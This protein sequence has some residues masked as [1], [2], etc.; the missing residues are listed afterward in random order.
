MKKKPKTY[1]ITKMGKEIVI[2]ILNNEYKVIVCWGDSEFVNKVG[3]KWQYPSGDIKI[4]KGV[5]GYTAINKELNPIIVLRNRPKR[6][7]EFGT[8]AHEAVHA[9]CNIW[10][11]IEEKN[12][13]EVFAHSV[14]AIVRETLNTD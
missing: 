3:I 4:E 8:L 2:P 14:G 10:D 1:H 5:R 9:V 11:K 13:D 12:I 6:A 7:D